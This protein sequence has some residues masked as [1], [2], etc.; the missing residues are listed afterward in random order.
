[1]M[2]V[3]SFVVGLG[4]IKGAIFAALLVG[5]VQSLTEFFIPDLA[6]VTI[7]IVMAI[8]LSA[9]PRGLLRGD[10]PAKRRSCYYNRKDTR[11]PREV[12]NQ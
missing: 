9:L 11:T 10:F 5:F 6:M 2:L 8:V 12:R 7:Y 1:M 4:S 3:L